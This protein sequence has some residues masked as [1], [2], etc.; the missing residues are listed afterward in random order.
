MDTNTKK[1]L[2]DKMRALINEK[3]SVY[4]WSNEDGVTSIPLRFKTEGNAKEY[5]GLENELKR[6]L[7]MPIRSYVIGTEE[8]HQ[9]AQRDFLKLKRAR[10]VKDHSAYV[11][12]VVMCCK[13]CRL[14][15]KTLKQLWSN[16]RHVKA[17]WLLMAAIVHSASFK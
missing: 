7:G 11:D 2:C 6:L 17:L 3:G 10:Q 1:T 8:E 12:A 5:V 9:K 15:P 4:V 16:V 14:H 13:L